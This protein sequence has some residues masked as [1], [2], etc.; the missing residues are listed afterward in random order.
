[1]NGYGANGPSTAGPSG[2]TATGT[3]IDVALGPTNQ[4]RLF[5]R[6]LTNGEAT[7]HLSGVE[8]A[9]ANSMRRVMMAD[10]PTV[11]KYREMGGKERAR[12]GGGWRRIR[13]RSALTQSGHLCRGG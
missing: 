11:G 13:E 1:M 8:T 10:V 6:N 12:K 3:T 5:I 2:G 7:F 4:P 9:Y